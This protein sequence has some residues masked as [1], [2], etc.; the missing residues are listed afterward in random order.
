MLTSV[1]DL[2]IVR[3]GIDHPDAL[4]LIEAVQAE[5]VVRYGGRDETPLDPPMF[6]DPRGAFYVGYVGP[7]PAATGAW[8]WHDPVAGVE[9]ARCTE[10]K[11][12][13]VAAEHRRRGLARFMLAHLESEARAAGSAAMILETGL[14]QPEAIELY[15]SSGYLPIPGF[16]FYRN[17]PLSRCFAKPLA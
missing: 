5:Y 9:A 11:R 15:A 14:R 8:R 3:V 10:I 13:Y 4:L 7:S 16:G 17:A 2:R 12:M 1:P 6:L